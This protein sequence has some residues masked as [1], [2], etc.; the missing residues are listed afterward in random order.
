M[1]G[2]RPTCPRGKYIINHCHFLPQ[3]TT[4]SG[5]NCFPSAQHNQTSVRP[6]SSC[7]GDEQRIWRCRL[8]VFGR[9]PENFCDF[10]PWGGVCATARTRNSQ[11]EVTTIGY[12]QALVLRECSHPFWP[13]KL[14]YV[15]RH[16][17]MQAAW[18]STLHP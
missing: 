5:K 14:I 16:R 15:L 18:R 12:G 13:E 8:F 17:V 9:L 1:G 2:R 3:S 7:V 11:S 4:A 6:I 10:C